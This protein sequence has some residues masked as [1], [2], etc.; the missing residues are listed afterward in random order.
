M[1]I[2][3]SPIKKT[4]IRRTQLYPL[5]FLLCI[6]TSCYGQ[7][8]VIYENNVSSYSI[9]TKVNP[10]DIEKSAASELQYHLKKTGEVE[11]PVKSDSVPSTANEI[12]LGRNAHLKQ[13]NLNEN[14]QELGK[15]GYIIRTVGSK[16]VIA[17][18]TDRGT[19]NGVYA[20]LEEMVGIRWLTPEVTHFPESRMLTL[21]K[22]NIRYVPAFNF[23]LL[24][25]L[26]AGDAS[27]AARHRLNAFH[28]HLNIDFP[29][30]MSDPRLE[31]SSTF[32]GTLAHTIYDLLCLGLT[33]AGKDEPYPVEKVFKEH[34]EYFSEINGNRKYKY[35]QLCFTNQDVPWLLAKG[36]KQRIKDTPTAKFVSISMMDHTGQCQCARCKKTYKELGTMSALYFDTV[37]KVA[38]IIEKEYPDILVESLAYHAEQIPPDNIKM[39]KNV[40]VRYAP[41]R[42]SSYYALDE[43]KHNTEGGLTWLCPPSATQLPRQ[44]KKWTDI[45]DHFWVWYYTLKLPIFH[46]NPNL[47]PLSRSFKAMRDWGVEG[48]FIEDLNW[49]KQHELNHIRAYLLAELMWNPDYDTKKGTQEFCRF[50][51]GPAYK[52]ALEYLDLLHSE[53]SWDWQEFRNG[54]SWQKPDGESFWDYREP[55]GCW[56]WFNEKPGPSYYKERYMHIAWTWNPP[57]KEVYFNKSKEIFTKAL[58]AVKGNKD[59]E[60]RIKVLQLPVHFAAFKYLPGDHPVFKEAYEEFFPFLDEIMNENPYH[61]QKADILMPEWMRDMAEEKKKKAEKV[62]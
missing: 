48:I 49:V 61:K 38:K 26:N 19:L 52:Q 44:I 51:Y 17:G 43:G 41:I 15:E 37:N 28:E 14:F 59:L 53:D 60:Y 40:V 5:L 42:M 22:L 1:N 23:R 16:L 13:L 29:G 30:L 11:L 8:I 56:D 34:P 4:T 47:R 12:I 36:A 3:M 20:F 39:R 46:P 25:T 7:E 27:W 54:G 2:I 6:S 31:D 33:P 35:S 45:T 58:K 57:L 24:Y 32:A 21:K 62:Q 10:S 9:V 50:Y 18:N 55:G